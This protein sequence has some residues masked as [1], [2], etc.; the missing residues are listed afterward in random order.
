M[1]VTTFFF[2]LVLHTHYLDFATFYKGTNIINVGG[3][4]DL[5]FFPLDKRINPILKL[6]C[7]N[8]PIVLRLSILLK[9][10]SNV[11]VEEIALCYKANHC[12]RINIT[13]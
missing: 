7:I 6:M 1:S 3:H 4:H 5:N 10:S 8:S 13:M 12:F 9:I 2:F 11:C